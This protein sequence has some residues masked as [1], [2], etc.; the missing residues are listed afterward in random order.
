MLDLF[1]S[2]ILPSEHYTSHSK[3]TK[4]IRL[5]EKDSCLVYEVLVPGIPKSNI[6]ILKTSYGL[7]IKT[8][9]PEH[10]DK[11][12]LIGKPISELSLSLNVPSKYSFESAELDMGV[13]SIVLRAKAPATAPIEW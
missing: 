9:Q 10:S 7:E 12:Y 4:R 11:S 13:L 5:Y 1:S 6:K 3:L 2:A 8:T